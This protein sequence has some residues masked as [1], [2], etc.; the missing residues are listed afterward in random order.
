[1]KLLLIAYI[2]EPVYTYE[3]RSGIGQVFAKL[4][5]DREAEPLEL[6]ELLKYPK[7]VFFWSGTPSRLAIKY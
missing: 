3:A 4:L 5:V 2:R 1:M 6:V 7:L